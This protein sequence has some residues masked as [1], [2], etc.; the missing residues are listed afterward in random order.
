[1]AANLA[2]VIFE[3]LLNCI[4]KVVVVLFWLNV[5]PFFIR[6]RILIFSILFCLTLAFYFLLFFYFLKVGK[7]QLEDLSSI[8]SLLIIDDLPNVCGNIFFLVGVY[9]HPKCFPHLFVFFLYCAIFFLFLS[10]ECFILDPLCFFKLFLLLL[11]RLN[12]VKNSLDFRISTPQIIFD[13]SAGFFDN[14]DT[15][16]QFL[17]YNFFEIFFFHTVFYLKIVSLLICV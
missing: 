1:M 16:S 10:G 11:N 17:L 5:L 4:L 3:Q 2:N 9:G 13:L 14:L 6:V 15:T 7:S 12:T 8:I